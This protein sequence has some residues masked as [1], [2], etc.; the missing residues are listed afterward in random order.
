M[1]IKPEI[2]AVARAMF[3]GGASLNDIYIKTKIERSTVSKKSKKEEWE[4]GKN[5]QIIDNEVKSLV[6]KSTLN[7]QQLNFHEQSVS[8]EVKKLKL[9][10]AFANAFD[11]I[12]LVT[13]I[14]KHGAALAT[15]S[16][17]GQGYKSAVEGLDKLSVLTGFNQRHANSQVNISNTN[18]QQNNVPKDFN[19]FY[20]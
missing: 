13:D 8:L 11:E 19:E 10:N 20:E 14:V 12:D 2:W 3:E 17:D 6:E 1:A 9:T 18:A 15:K 7:Q 4:K 16:E 5:S